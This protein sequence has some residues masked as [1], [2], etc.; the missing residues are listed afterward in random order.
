MRRTK[1][2]EESI[3]AGH[4]TPTKKIHNWTLVSDS[5]FQN[6]EIGEFTQFNGIGLDVDDYHKA[7]YLGI[8]IFG[9]SST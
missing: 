5:L 2:S 4:S 7:V 1:E 6:P 8:F 3:V 9:F